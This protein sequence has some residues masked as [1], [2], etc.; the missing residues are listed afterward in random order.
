MSDFPPARRI[1]TNGIHLSVHQAGPEDGLPVLLLH[2]WPELARSWKNQIGPLAAAGFRVI[3]PD[4]RGFGGSDAPT[5]VAAYGIDSLIADLTG[6]L[7]A[8]G[9]RKAVWCGH[10]WGGLIVW[11]AA[12]LAPERVA[13]VIGVNTP[14]LPRPPVSPLDLL[15]QRFGEDHYFNRFQPLGLAEQA[16]SGREDDFFAF[17]FARPPKRLP[18]TVPASATHLLARFAQFTGRKES[19]IAVP[20]DER[21]HYAAAYRRSGFRGGINY[22][23]NVTANWQRMDGVD[24]LVRQPALMIG[25]ELDPFLPPAFMDGMEERVPDLHKHVIQG[26]GHWTQWEAPD[27]LSTQMIAWL[28]KRRADLA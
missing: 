22:Y 24:P 8:L 5:E 25:A 10:D 9:L 14:H 23:R 18:A 1:R 15:V 28:H 26:C 21:A 12:L 7:D 11:P 19:A 13:G 6:L 16:L 27:E 17:V 2:G 3:A 4:L 20:A